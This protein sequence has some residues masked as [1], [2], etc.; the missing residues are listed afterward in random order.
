MK[1][2]NIL[3]ITLVLGLFVIFLGNPISEFYSVFQF[4]SLSNV[5]FDSQSYLYRVIRGKSQQDNN[6]LGLRN[7]GV[8]Q[9]SI[10]N[11]SSLLKHYFPYNLPKSEE[12]VSALAEDLDNT[13]VDVDKV[14]EYI[15]EPIA[16]LSEGNI[17]NFWKNATA[18]KY[19]II[20]ITE[21]KYGV[22][23]RLEQ[24]LI[25]LIKD[26]SKNSINSAEEFR[27]NLRVLGI[28]TEDKPTVAK[29][30]KLAR[31]R[32][33][34]AIE[35]IS[36]IATI[37]ADSKP[38]KY[39]L[40][41][42]D[43]PTRSLYMRL[44]NYIARGG[45]WSGRVIKIYDK[46][47]V[48]VLEDMEDK[49]SLEIFED[50]LPK[51]IRLAGGDLENFDSRSL[52]MSQMFKNL[53]SIK[54][55]LYELK[56]KNI[57]VASMLKIS[58]PFAYDLAMHLA[59]QDGRRL[60]QEFRQS[61]YAIE[62]TILFLNQE[63]EDLPTAL[64]SILKDIFEAVRG[65]PQQ[66]RDNLWG[67]VINFGQFLMD[68][69][70]NLE[71]VLVESIHSAYISSKEGEFLSNIETIQNLVTKLINIGI[72]P[73]GISKIL[74]EEVPEKAKISKGDPELFRKFLEDIV[75]NHLN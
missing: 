51:T 30:L 17:E 44:R 10:Y 8:S 61:L 52:N 70:I 11:I 15:I 69:N 3:L 9:D 62:K 75:V 57:N 56:N 45:I 20:D 22:K 38:I 14:L 29:I 21:G 54:Y 72:K 23:E 7:Y 31:V 12:V 26:A 66:F 35:K 28:T 25:G 43:I 47:F 74:I 39:R 71:Q 42:I 5:N 59:T 16:E 49:V 55:F 13:D 1:F 33:D 63:I 4:R 67:G 68:K 73:D 64:E 53:D 2:K 40:L 58:F 36:N 24:I 60:S 46:E 37:L 65:K 41:L 32:V 18:V 27:K 19:M 50:C 48:P 6:L 34:K